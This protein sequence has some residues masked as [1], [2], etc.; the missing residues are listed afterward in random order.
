MIVLLGR[1]DS[2]ADALEDYCRWLRVGLEKRGHPSQLVRVSWEEAGPVRALRRLWRESRKW[3][4]QWVLAQYTALSWS[5]RGFPLLFLAALGV[6]KVRATRLAV[7]FHD[8]GAYSGTRLIDRMRRALQRCVM[9]TAYRWAERSIVNVPVGTVS[10]LPPKPAKAAFIPVG[11]NIPALLPAQH[12]GHRPLDRPKVI[13]VFGIT[14]GGTVG[15]EIEDIAFAASLASR[16]L[17]PLRLVTLGRGS[18]EAESRLRQALSG[19]KIEFAALGVL[20]P[21][22]VSRT[23]ADSDA[24]LFVRGELSTQRGSAIAGIACGLPLVAYSGPHT[25]HP[26]TEAGVIQVPQGDREELGKALVRVLTDEPLWQDL[27]QRS[28]RAQ[29]EY[30]SWSAIADKLVKVLNDD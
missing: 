15:D 14:G 24:L 5:R 18:K 23:L 13:A 4:D 20:P 10:W 19:V 3:K 12:N 6:L 7:V 8:P 2:P 11:A 25:A 30:F 26:I 17:Q 29:R 1:R 22:E 27:H 28:L 9:R 16:R 21:E